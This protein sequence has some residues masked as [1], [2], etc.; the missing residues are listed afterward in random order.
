MAKDA[1]YIFEPNES[2][3]LFVKDTTG[4]RGIA[5]ALRATF[6]ADAEWDD[7]HLG[8]V[9]LLLADYTAGDKSVIIPIIRAL[10]VANLG[11]VFLR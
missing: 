9:A 7:R 3:D 11:V 10:R 1:V 6:D 2:A 5:R 4:P 8:S